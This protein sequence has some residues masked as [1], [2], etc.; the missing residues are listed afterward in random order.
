MSFPANVPRGLLTLGDNALNRQFALERQSLETSVYGILSQLGFHPMSPTALATPN[1]GPE[2]HAS[3]ECP[4]PGAPHPSFGALGANCLRSTDWPILD[5]YPGAMPSEREGSSGYPSQHQDLSIAVVG[6]YQARHETHP[7]TSASIHH[8]A[9]AQ[10]WTADVTWIPTPELEGVTAADLS[11]YDGVWIAPMS[12]YRSLRGVL[13]AIEVA[14]VGDIPLLGTCAGFQH[15]VLEFAR[16]VLGFVDAQSAEY[17]PSASRLF[18][19]ALTCSL[20]G[21]TM[22]VVFAPG[23]EHRLRTGPRQPPS[24]ITATSG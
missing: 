10:E 5:R 14:R 6:D 3:G 9:D 8:A 1:G 16:N 11:D 13:D 2:F 19:S 22:T 4:G 18:I 23:L 21:Q 17:D 15:I 24:V 7:A 20:A 12:P